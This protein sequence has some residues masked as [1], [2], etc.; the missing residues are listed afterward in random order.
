MNLS[1]PA[2]L[3]RIMASM[4]EVPAGRGLVVGSTGGGNCMQRAEIT[5]ILLS[6]AALP[7]RM[8]RRH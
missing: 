2:G 5:R 6:D 7:D 1:H 3:P 4:G 8:Q